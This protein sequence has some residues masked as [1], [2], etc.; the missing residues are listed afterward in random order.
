MQFYGVLLEMHCHRYYFHRHA[1]RSYNGAA[2]TV[3]K[4]CL[5]W[6]KPRVCLIVKNTNLQTTIE[7]ANMIPFPKLPQGERSFEAMINSFILP[8]WFQPH[9]RSQ[10]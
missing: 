5:S 8:Q 6:Q 7:M 10:P 2:K 3:Q 1:L 4:M 9:L